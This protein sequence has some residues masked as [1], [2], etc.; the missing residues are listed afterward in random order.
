MPNLITY[1]N[2]G[3]TGLTISFEFYNSAG[4][5][6]SAVAGV[7]STPGV[8]TGVVPGTFVAGSYSCRVRWNGYLVSVQNFT[9]DGISV[10]AVVSV[11]SANIPGHTTNDMTAGQPQQNEPITFHANNLPSGKNSAFITNQF[12]TLLNER[13]VMMD[14]NRELIAQNGFEVY[15]IQNPFTNVDPLYGEDRFFQLNAAQTKKL[16]VYL[17]DAQG[18]YEGGAFFSKF[19][20]QNRQQSEFIVSVKEWQL[21]FG[22]LRPLEG[23]LLYLP[24]WNQ[25]GPTD[26]MRVNFVDKFD[27]NGFYPLGEHFTFTLQ[28]E[29]WSYSSEKMATGVPEID[30]QEAQFS[31]DV[32]VNPDLNAEALKD[33]VSVQTLSDPIIDWNV[34]NPFGRG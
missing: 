13:S 12:G 17:K 3:A 28:T 24:R 10:S 5:Y 23:D 9:W 16:V 27:S 4:T 21:I 18:G 33:N 8:Y 29:K 14:I 15:Y 6:I 26:F 32:A 1:T 11:L 19:G 31:A 34:N 30:S 7:E 22:A 20:F 2:L 25:F